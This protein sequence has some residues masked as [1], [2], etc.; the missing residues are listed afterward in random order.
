MHKISATPAEEREKTAGETF[1]SSHSSLSLVVHEK[2]KREALEEVLRSE[3]FFRAEQLR[4]F[5]RYICE[6]ELAGRGSELCESL[7]GIEALGRPADY[8]PTEDA[9]V[10]RRAGD[11][12]DK[13]QEVYATELAGS[14]VRIELPKGK[15]VPRFVRMTPE[16]AMDVAPALLASQRAPAEPA[17]SG[18][19]NEPVETALSPLLDA[20]MSATRLEP[21]R[22]EPAR[23]EFMPACRR[24]FSIFW[25]AVGWVLGALMVSTGFLAFLRFRSSNVQTAPRTAAAAPPVSHSVVIEPGTSYEAEA[26]G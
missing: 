18:H 19:G 14:R 10:R 8:T 2:E 17:P 15:Y 3:R 7:I 4:N 20:N 22:M 25:L 9:S 16:R 23:F 24:R 13:L 1:A 26:P 21:S 11:L 5:L 12:R 6:M